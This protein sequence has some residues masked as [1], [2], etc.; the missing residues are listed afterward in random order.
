MTQPDRII[1]RVHPGNH[2]EVCPSCGGEVAYQEGIQ[3]CRD[4]G[5]TNKQA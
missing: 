4:C 5:W 1:S 2:H 3:I